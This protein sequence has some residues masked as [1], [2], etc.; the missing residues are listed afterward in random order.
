MKSA[1]D[2]WALRKENSSALER[3]QIEELERS[4]QIGCVDDGETPDFII[5]GVWP[6]GKHGALRHNCADCGG[7]VALNVDTGLAGHQKW[8]DVK[9]LCWD[10]FKQRVE[11][12]PK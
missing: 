6:S 3:A 10:C 4:G 8:P 11:K 1:K 7:Y 9:V 2:A 12:E 5:G